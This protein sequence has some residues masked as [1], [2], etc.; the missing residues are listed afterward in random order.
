LFA[1]N[2]NLFV[3][4]QSIDEVSAIANICISKLNTWFFS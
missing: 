2:T 1:D 3:G 4:S